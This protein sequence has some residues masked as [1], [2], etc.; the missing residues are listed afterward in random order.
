MMLGCCSDAS[1]LG[2][3]AACGAA[4]AAAP[5]VRDLAM[6]AALEA[7]F[8]ARM[9]LMGWDRWDIL[10]FRVVLF[11]VFLRSVFGKLMV[12]GWEG[13]QFIPWLG[14]KNNAF[15]FFFLDAYSVWGALS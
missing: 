13:L 3:V 1:G 2:K 4:A 7:T 14:A 8:L 5:T 10:R 15:L 11:R 9:R 6:L 12:F